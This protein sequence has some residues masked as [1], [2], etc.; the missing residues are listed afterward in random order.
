MLRLKQYFCKHNLTCI[1]INKNCQENL[2]YCNKCDVYYIQHYGIGIGYFTKK[3][4]TDLNNWANP[5]PKEN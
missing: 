4:P 1:G 2:W 3:L 5:Y